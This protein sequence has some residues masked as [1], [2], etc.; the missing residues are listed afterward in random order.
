ML[1][2]LALTAVAFAALTFSAAAQNYNFFLHNRANG[3]V[4]NGFYTQ[5][6]GRWSNNWLSGRVAPGRNVPM[7]WASQAGSCRV[8]FRVSWVDWGTQDFTMD[9]CKNNPSNLYMKDE[10]F[11]WD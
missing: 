8:P 7:R 3:W 9:W 11:T 5:Q 10:G 2:R 6:N 4:I 1:S